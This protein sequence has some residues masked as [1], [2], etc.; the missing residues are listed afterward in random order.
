[1]IISDKFIPAEWVDVKV[2]GKAYEVPSYRFGTVVVGSGAAGLNAADLI[3]EDVAVVTEGLMMGTSRNTGSDK[4][5]Y[6]KLTLSGDTP[7]SV[8][9]MAKSYFAGGSMDG[10][11]A[12]AEAAG[13]ARA[14]LRLVELGVPF[15]YNDYGE[16]AGYQTDHDTRTRAT[17]CGPLTSRYMTEAL[18]EAVRRRGVPIFDGFRVVKLLTD[19][20]PESSCEVGADGASV[21]TDGASVGASG[22]AVGANGAAVGADGASVGASGASVGADGAA[23]GAS[24]ASVGAD[25]ASVGANGASVGASGASVGADGASVGADGASVVTDGAS[26]GADG[27]SVG[28]D[29]AAVGVPARMR[30]RGVAAMCPELA[31]DAN[32]YGVAIFLAD[33]LV[34]ATGGPSAIYASTVYPESQTCAHGVLLEAGVLTSNV[35]ESQ[36][37]LASTKFRWNLSGTYQQVLPRYI[38]TLPDGSDE[39]EFLAE[40]F[41]TP[42]RMLTAEFRKGY[43]W[44]FDPAKLDAESGNDSSKVDIAVFNERRKGRRVFMDFRRN[45]SEALRDGKFDAEVIGDEARAYLESSG[46]LLETPI[47]RLAA[48]NQPAIELYASHGINLYSEPLELDMCAQHNNGGFAVDSSYKSSLEGLWV[49]GEAAGVFGVHRP[50]GSALNSTQVGSRRAAEAIKLAR[51]SGAS[52]PQ[53]E[54]DVELSLPELG[55]GLSRNEILAKRLEYGRVMSACGAFLRDESGIRAAISQIR[56]ELDVFSDYRAET[57]ELARELTINRD[58]LLTQLVY[59]SAILGYISDGGLSRGSYLVVGRDG[60]DREH[61]TKV[62]EARLSSNREVS[63]AFRDVRPIPERENWFERVWASYRAKQK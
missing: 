10:D 47:E 54:L 3:G 36:Y 7:D 17:S 53:A 14:F 48:M 18:T 1:M 49:V 24:D 20:V 52:T 32:P 28:T 40:S 29:G 21:G 13:S 5:T 16:F 25:G 62:L 9:D 60:I 61:F 50:G 57:V 12:L 56:A 38:S 4:Q 63:I 30:A 58:I 43:Q 44:P 31:S 59:L 33:G 27:A 35:T 46:A 42:E 26:V 34:W 39:R 6:Y 41:P 2:N 11:L 15:P 22:A 19:A 55:A 37:G 8:G 45:P 23:V 51:R